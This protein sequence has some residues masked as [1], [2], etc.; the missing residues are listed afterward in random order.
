L[1]REARWGVVFL[2]VDQECL[3]LPH[4]GCN[5]S[6]PDP[7]CAHGSYFDAHDVAANRDSSGHLV[8]A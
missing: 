4:L 7:A 1:S 3:Y 2:G 5:P 6:P 8:A